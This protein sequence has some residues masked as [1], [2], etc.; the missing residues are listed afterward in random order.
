MTSALLP[1]YNEARHI[2]EVLRRASEA[3]RKAGE[4]H[5]LVSEVLG[6]KPLL[7]ER[8]AP[9]PRRHG[10]GLHGSGAPARQ[11]DHRQG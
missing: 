1:P 2:Q 9:A 8:P 10:A 5:E 4:D 3:L 11:L 7:G 6:A